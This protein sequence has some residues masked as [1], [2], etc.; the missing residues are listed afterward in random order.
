MGSQSPGA[1]IVAPP[2]GSLV[3]LAAALDAAL[4]VRGAAQGLPSLEAAAGASPPHLW[5]IAAAEL[6]RAPAT[7]AAGL[8]GDAP[9]IGLLPE[10][11]LGA[12]VALML[13]SPRIA[14]VVAARPLDSRGLTALAQRVLP[15]RGGAAAGGVGQLMT[16][17]TR[18][19][20]STVADHAQSRSLLAQLSAFAAECGA[21]A[22]LLAP[23]EQC[24]DEMLA[25]ALYGAPVDAR[26][27]R[28]FAGLSTRA[29]IAWRTDREVSVQLACDGARLAVGVRDTFG[30]LVRDTA[31]AHL[32][33]GARAAA[34]RASG[35]R[36][37]ATGGAGLGLYLMATSASA[38]YISVWPGAATEVVCTFELQ[39]PEPRLA[40]LGCVQHSEAQSPRAPARRARVGSRR[41]WAAAAGLLAAAAAGTAVIARHRADPSALEPASR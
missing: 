13:A 3:E 9:V 25:N 23:I 33:R 28:L 40:V 36:G 18:L 37:R 8:P 24:A 27:R 39:A 1:I 15:A 5:L 4:G 10:P 20:A 21:P 35:A 26:G 14:G 16:P 34:P 29:R 38:V 6:V 19:H 41:R 11:D 32:H 12:A 31:L 2:A 7:I 22:K 30:S 17:G